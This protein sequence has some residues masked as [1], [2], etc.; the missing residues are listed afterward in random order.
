MNFHFIAWF[1]ERVASLKNLRHV[2][3]LNLKFEPILKTC[4]TNA[5]NVKGN[6]RTQLGI[7]VWSWMKLISSNNFMFKRSHPR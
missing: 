5:S 6:Q 3:Q 4:G 7:Y 2:K 1:T